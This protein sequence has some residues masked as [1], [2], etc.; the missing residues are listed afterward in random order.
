MLLPHAKAPRGA[1][2]RLSLVV[3]PLDRPS[4]LPAIPNKGVR[5]HVDL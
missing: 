4:S 2:H 1:T 5:V 3:V